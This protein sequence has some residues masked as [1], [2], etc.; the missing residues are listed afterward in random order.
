MPDSMQNGIRKTR[1]KAL[2]ALHELITSA[3]HHRS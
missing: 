2:N 1:Q 3:E